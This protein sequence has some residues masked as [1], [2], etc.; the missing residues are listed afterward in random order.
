M[1]AQSISCDACTWSSSSAIFAALGYLWQ[2]LC[3]IAAKE[4]QLCSCHVSQFPVCYHGRVEEVC[5]TEREDGIEMGT[6][7]TYQRHSSEWQSLT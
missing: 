4:Y 2:V 7:D 6:P 1:L 5:V 3:T